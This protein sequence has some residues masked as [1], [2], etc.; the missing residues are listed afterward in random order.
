[1]TDEECTQTLWFPVRGLRHTEGASELSRTALGSSQ[2]P[3]PLAFPAFLF[4]VAR[5][6]LDASHTCL[7]SF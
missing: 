1:M 4:C 2:N 7:D 3:W 6:K 5:T